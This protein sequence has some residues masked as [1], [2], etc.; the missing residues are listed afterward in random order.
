M[1]SQPVLQK[2]ITPLWGKIGEL[3]SSHGAVANDRTP[4][5]ARCLIDTASASTEFMLPRGPARLRRTRTFSRTDR[6]A[7]PADRANSTSLSSYRGVKRFTR[8]FKK[9]LCCTSFFRSFRVSRTIHYASH[10]PRSFVLRKRIV[11]SGGRVRSTE[12]GWPWLG[13]EMA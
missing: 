10:V 9:P 3:T 6:S 8:R 11:A 4:R 2:S 13:C 7:A 5:E 1:R 12:H